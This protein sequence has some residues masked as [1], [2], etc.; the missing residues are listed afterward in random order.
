MTPDLVWYFAYG[1]NMQ[2]ATFAGRRGIVAARALPARLA[3]WQLV[4]D[5]P[6]LLPMG[7]GMANVVETPGAEVLGVAYAIT[8]DDLAHV[9]LTEGVLIENYRRVAVEVVALVGGAPFEAWTLTSERRG[10]GLLPSERY[11]ALLIDGAEQH[12]LP[13]EYVAWLRARPAVAD[14]PESLEVR[15]FID[16]ALKKEPR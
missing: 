12:G 2:P 13:A 3:G 5:K 8:A 9:D 16:R 7:Q 15:A 4:L 14:S 6:P 1:S 11:M 10:V